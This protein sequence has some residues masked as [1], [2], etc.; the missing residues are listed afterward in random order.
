MPGYSLTDVMERLRPDLR[1]VWTHSST[2][3]NIWVLLYSRCFCCCACGFR[4]YEWSC[5]HVISHLVNGQ[6]A[7][8]DHL[9]FGRNKGGHDQAGAVTEAQTW[10]H[11]QSLR[12]GNTRTKSRVHVCWGW[13]ARAD[14]LTDGG[15]ILYLE[16]LGVSW[17]GWNWN[18]LISKNSVD[19]GTLSH[20][21]I[22]NLTNTTQFKCKV[23]QVGVTHELILEPTSPTVS[24]PSLHLGP[25][26]AALNISRSSS[27]RSRRLELRK[28]FSPDEGAAS[29]S[30]SASSSEHVCQSS[31]SSVL[32]CC[33]STLLLSSSSFAPSAHLWDISSLSGRPSPSGSLSLDSGS[34]SS[35]SCAETCLPFERVSHFYAFL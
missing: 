5:R 27:L 1:S 8:T 22:P 25:L 34:S 29:S 15:R 33:S 30:S 21:R 20:I 7:R 28:E 11:I 2:I 4:G 6:D 24:C 9:C 17:S 16:V 32:S 26:W 3:V 14:A 31:S 12:E 35:R 19:G 18:L 13:K 23:K 10:L